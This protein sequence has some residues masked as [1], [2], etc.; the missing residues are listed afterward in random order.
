[1]KILLAGGAG[2]LGCHLAESLVSRGYGVDILDNLASGSKNNLISLGDKI[3]FVKRDITDFKTEARNDFVVNF[4]SR[5]SRVEWEKKPVEVAITNSVGS[6]NLIKIVLESKA[7]YIY[8]S[9]SEVYGDAR[10]VPTP[11]SYMG[12][13]SSTGS[14]SPYDEGKDSVRP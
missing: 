8:G 10:V 12:C 5:A 7:R 9:S 3:R 13:V 4:A 6:I 14:R 11:E 1:M 2:F